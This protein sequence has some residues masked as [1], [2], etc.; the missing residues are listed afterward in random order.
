MCRITPFKSSE[1]TP[2]NQ[3]TPFIH[4]MSSKRIH[5]FI[6]LFA[7]TD[8]ATAKGVMIYNII[9]KIA[10]HCD[11]GKFGVKIKPIPD[12]RGLSNT[13]RTYE[14][15]V[16]QD[17]LYEDDGLVYLTNKLVMELLKIV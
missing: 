12:R 4:F 14:Y 7:D 3:L 1:L 16:E 6:N 5:N 17:F 10:E 11:K 13:S 8:N 2:V 9:N 15:L